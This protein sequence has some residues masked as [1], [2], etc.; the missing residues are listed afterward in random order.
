MSSLR[1]SLS[2]VHFD[3]PSTSTLQS[4]R[5]PSCDS[6]LTDSSA[7]PRRPPPEYRHYSPHILH[8]RSSTNERSFY[9]HMRERGSEYAVDA[10]ESEGEEREDVGEMPH[11]S[12]TDSATRYGSD[13][14]QKR[15]SMLIRGRRQPSMTSSDPDVDIAPGSS[16]SSA[17]KMSPSF[18]SNLKRSLQIDMKDLVGDSVAN[19]RVV[20][21]FFRDALKTVPLFR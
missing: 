11:P 18:G 2:A 17:A 20:C 16:A 21:S 12:M 8:S 14:E 3:E 5:Q 9:D 13:T 4:A 7:E 10:D 1:R 15:P 6:S 19:V